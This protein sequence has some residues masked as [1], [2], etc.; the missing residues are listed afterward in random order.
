MLGILISY[1]IMIITE[2]SKTFSSYIRLSETYL[3][4]IVNQLKL[5]QTLLM[6]L[7]ITSLKKNNLRIQCDQ[8]LEG[9]IWELCSLKL[10]L[11]G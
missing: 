9:T 11:M 5:Q 1:I 7:F 8:I 10:Y 4:D 6:H 2:A 3:V